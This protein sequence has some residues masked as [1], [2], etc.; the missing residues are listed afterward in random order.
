ML[1]QALRR[2][3]SL[4]FLYKASDS[5]GEGKTTQNCLLGGIVPPYLGMCQW[6]GVGALCPPNVAKSARKLV[7]SQSCIKRVGHSIFRD[8]F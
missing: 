7:K 3:K 8:L 1:A 4:I 6:E 5:V 2:D